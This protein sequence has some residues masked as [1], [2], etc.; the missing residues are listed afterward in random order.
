MCGGRGFLWRIS[1]TKPNCISSFINN[2]YF[3]RIAFIIKNRIVVFIQSYLFMGVNYYDFSI[4]CQDCKIITRIDMNIGIFIMSTALLFSILYPLLNN[5]ILEQIITADRCRS[6]SCNCSGLIKI[7]QFILINLDWLS[8]TYWELTLNRCTG[9]I[10]II[11]ICIVFNIDAFSTSK[12]VTPQCINIQFLCNPPT[13]QVSV[14][15]S[16]ITPIIHCVGIVGIRILVVF[17]CNGILIQDEYIPV[18]HTGLTSFV[19]EPC[20]KFFLSVCPCS[21]GGAYF[22][23]EGNTEVHLLIGT[24]PPKVRV[25]SAVFCIRM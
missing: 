18:K 2:S 20:N 24:A 21:F 12:N 7:C 17:T 4:T 5:P 16:T 9:L 8:F 19:Q 13:I 25:C 23:S 10:N 6:S 1:C 15:S 22:I 11:S 14:G 3:Y